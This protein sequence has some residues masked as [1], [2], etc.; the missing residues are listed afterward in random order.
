MTVKVSPA[1]AW[2]QLRGKLVHPMDPVTAVAIALICA[3][4]F[5]DYGLTCYHVSRG[6]TELNPVLASLFHSG[7]F[8][9]AFWLKLLL[10]V[11]GV[12][13]LAL[14]PAKRL[15][16]LALPTLLAAYMGVIAYH[17]IHL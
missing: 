12:S 7:R 16:R 10:T 8:I 1:S 17:I 6:A 3:A 11:A 5:I 4:S 14:F 13:V 9:E 15:V 2:D